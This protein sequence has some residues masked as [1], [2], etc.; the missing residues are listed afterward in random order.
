MDIKDKRVVVTG[1][2]SGIGL[3][4]AHAFAKAGANVFITGRRASSLDEAAAGH[5]GLVP[6][7]CDVTVDDQVI[8][9]KQ[10]VDAA[11]GADVLVNNA[12]VMEFFNILDGYPLEKQIQEIHIDAI[13]PLRMVHHFLPSM[14]QRNATI[15][16][17]S[18]GI[19]YVPFAQAPVYS[20]AK[21]FL[22]A[23]TQCLRAQLRD[24]SVRVV[25]L[26]PPV[27][28]TP[29]AEG[30]GTAFPRM[31]PEKLAAALMRGLKRGDVEIAPGI[32]TPLKWL[33]RLLP[34]VAFRQMN[35]TA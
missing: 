32:S 2:S 27:V 7:V 15:I 10:T 28:D 21:A 35:K 13:G 29:L 18:S 1:G 33:S 25:E 22:H 4:L 9:L 23:W 30:F 26:L 3:A 8:A 14:L 6:V 34:P 24:T 19:A 31:Q 5:R 12:G 20:G 16:N 17:V 11:G